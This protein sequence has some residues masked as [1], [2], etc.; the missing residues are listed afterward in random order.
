MNCQARRYV[1]RSG[2]KLEIALKNLAIS[3]IDKCIL[4]IGAS[5][6][7]FT[8]CCLQHGAAKVIAVDRGTRQLAQHLRED[9]RV[10]VCEKTDIRDYLTNNPSQE[11][12]L[13]VADLSFVPLTIVLPPVIRHYAN[14]F[15]V[16]IKPQFELP[17]RLVP[18]GGVVRDRHRWQLA[19][20]KVKKMFHDAGY[21]N[22]RIQQTAVVGV[23]G[24]RE[25]FC[26]ARKDRCLKGQDFSPRKALKRSIGNGKTIVDF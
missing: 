22:L 1:S 25:F 21:T 3:V 5:T 20:G 11:I 6:G 24:N 18:P 4:D 15:L 19:I 9:R 2:K 14:D 26:Y 7:G 13:I 16:L 23:K 17:R 10:V 12:D 8:D